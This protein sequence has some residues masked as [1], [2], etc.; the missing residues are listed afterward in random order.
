MAD[1]FQA[2]F[3]HSTNFLEV[4][5]RSINTLPSTFLEFCLNF[6]AAKRLPA[7]LQS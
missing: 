2:E 7:T 1:I 5:L 4:S 3:L 6:L